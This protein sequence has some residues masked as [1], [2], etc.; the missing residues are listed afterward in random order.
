[1]YSHKLWSIEVASKGGGRG[2]VS[3]SVSCSVSVTSLGGG[4]LSVYAILRAWEPA[5]ALGAPRMEFGHQLGELG[6]GGGYRR[7]ASA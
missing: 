7:Q 2:W 4:V 6:V 1:M 3:A 5:V